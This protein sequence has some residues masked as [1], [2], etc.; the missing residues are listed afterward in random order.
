MTF[1]LKPE[2]SSPTGPLP[3]KLSVDGKTGMR[4]ENGPREEGPTGK[5]TQKIKTQTYWWKKEGGGR[6][7]GSKRGGQVFLEMGGQ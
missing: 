6:G 5:K 7:R 3:Y 4:G 2:Q 1:A